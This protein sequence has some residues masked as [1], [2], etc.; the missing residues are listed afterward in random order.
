MKQLRKLLLMAP[1]LFALVLVGCSNPTGG[2]GSNGNGDNGTDGTNGSD[3]TNGTNEQFEVSNLEAI[4]GDGNVTLNWTDP[5]ASEF[6]G[7]EITWSP[8]APA[9]PATRSPGT[10]TYLASGLT[11]GTEYTFTVKTVHTN[12][13]T[14]D[15]KT[16]TATP[17]AAGNGDGGSTSFSVNEGSFTL[18]ITEN[19]TETEISGG[20]VFGIGSEASTFDNEAF[21]IYM[22]DGEK[23]LDEEGNVVGDWSE[24]II[25]DSDD[26]EIPSTGTTDI[27]RWDFS[28]RTLASS[29]GSDGG[30]VEITSSSDSQLEGTFSFEAS[31]GGATVS[32]SFTAERTQQANQV[33]CA[34]GCE[35]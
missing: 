4:P 34:P 12:D 5:T 19:G 3:G 23:T 25:R 13:S 1:L 9:I 31:L 30:T 29:Y 11:N 20:A 18:T 28:S 14:S 2:D 7:V 21:V 15:G 27:S 6:D 17:Q 32:G 35:N 22:L 8:D 26:V 10:E 16:V 33:I 24:L